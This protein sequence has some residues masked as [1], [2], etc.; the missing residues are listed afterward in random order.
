[1]GLVLGLGRRAWFSFIPAKH[2]FTTNI[3]PDFGAFHVAGLKLLSTSRIASFNPLQPYALLPVTLKPLLHWARHAHSSS[4]E[5]ILWTKPMRSSKNTA[6]QSW[7]S[8]RWTV[9]MP[10]SRGGSCASSS[11]EACT[12][13]RN[14]PLSVNTMSLTIS[15]HVQKCWTTVDC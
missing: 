8:R 12:G 2:L 1:M 5:Q 9:P 6:A 7:R 13:F 3:V 10:S 14:C 4:L 11:A 15:I